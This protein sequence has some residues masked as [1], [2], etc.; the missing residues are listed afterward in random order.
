MVLNL[1]GLTTIAILFVAAPANALS[2]DS[3][4]HLARHQAIARQISL[5]EP[6][7]KRSVATRCKVRSISSSVQPSSTPPPPAPTSSKAPPPA[8][9]PTPSPSPSPAPKQSSG[10]NRK[11]GLAWA[12]GG[13]P[14]LKNFLSPKVS[15]YVYFFLG[16]SSVLI[17]SLSSVYT[18]SPHP[19][20]DLFGL[21]FIPMLWGPKQIDDF[22][23]LVV[24]GYAKAVLGFNEWVSVSLHF[25]HQ[26]NK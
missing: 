10:G 8:A 25:S 11:T 12:L 14:S 1:L 3:S 5:P 7:V 22:T 2:V 4:V 19:P 6:L 16:F 21:E 24:P 26:I 13:D 20:P 23:R 15:T 18:W 17:F 9:S